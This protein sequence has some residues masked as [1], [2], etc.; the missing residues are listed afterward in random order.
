MSA[1]E[2]NRMKSF[3]D[4]VRNTWDESGDNIYLW[5]FY[6]WETGGRGDGT[7][8]TSL[9]LLDDYRSG[10]GDS[11]P[12]NEFNAMVYPYLCQRIVDVIIGKGDAQAITGID[13]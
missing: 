6:Y 11:H 8:G 12:D 13:E 5:D 2:A 1:D 10:T 7:V 9:Y 3:T 4:W